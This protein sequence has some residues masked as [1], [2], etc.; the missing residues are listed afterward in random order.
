MF[1]LIV[2]THHVLY[3]RY[4]VKIHWFLGITDDSAIS[5]SSCPWLSPSM[6]LHQVSASEFSS[7]K[8]EQAAESC[9]SKNC[10]SDF[11]CFLLLQCESHYKR[12]GR[13]YHSEGFH[14]TF[15]R[16]PA[17]SPWYGSFLE[18]SQN[19]T[20]KHVRISF[21]EGKSTTNRLGAL[22]YIATKLRL[23]TLINKNEVA[24]RGEQVAW[25]AKFRGRTSI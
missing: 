3:L 6:Q 8:L 4:E 23:F 16:P 14:S 21:F 2:D 15:Y 9:V 17:H 11:C 19:R 12:G 7:I 1:S 18:V 25:P 13:C 10:C 24:V 5:P 20:S 22:T